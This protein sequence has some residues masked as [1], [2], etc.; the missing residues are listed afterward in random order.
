LGIVLANAALQ[1]RGGQL[2]A[3]LNQLSIA[4]AYCGGVVVA[5]IGVM[6]AVSIIG[7]AVMGRPIIGDFE[8]VEIGTAIAGSLFLAYCQAT[9][10]NI[11]VDV[12]TLKVGPRTRDALDRFG[13]LLMAVMYFT[14]GWRTFVGALGIS[15]TGETS[16]LM[17]VPTWIGYAGMLPGVFVAGVVALAQALGVVVSER[18]ADE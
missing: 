5:L 1:R 9:Y 18:S 7:R 2:G 17:G 10:G 16:M 13:S 11:S 8:L 12:F 15:Q 4:L 6:S 14:V 3:A